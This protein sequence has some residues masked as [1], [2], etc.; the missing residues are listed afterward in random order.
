[1]SRSLNFPVKGNHN[2]I[3]KDSCYE[4]GIFL[5][6]DIQIVRIF[7]IY[8]SLILQLCGLIELMEMLCS[9]DRFYPDYYEEIVRPMSL[10]NVRKKIK[11]TLLPLFGFK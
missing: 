11:V 10:S 5:F 7:Q 3:D 8:A 2:K 6:I 1:M 9:V 4:E